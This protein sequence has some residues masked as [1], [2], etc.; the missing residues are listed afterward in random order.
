VQNCTLKNMQNQTFGGAKKEITH[1]KFK[2]Y[3]SQDSSQFFMSCFSNIFSIYSS[4]K[5]FPIYF[6]GQEF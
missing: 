5:N 4:M 6:F 1:K 2:T 3:A